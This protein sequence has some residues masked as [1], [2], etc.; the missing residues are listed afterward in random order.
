MIRFEAIVDANGAGDRRPPDHPTAAGDGGDGELPP[1]IVVR[2]E[3]DSVQ[4]MFDDGAEPFAI[5]LDRSGARALGAALTA[6]GG[7]GF[8]RTGRSSERPSPNDQ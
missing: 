3:G 5:T 7:S 6:A 2:R 8:F 1:T 4:I